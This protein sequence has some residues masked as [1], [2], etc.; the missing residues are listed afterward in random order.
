MENRTATPDEIAAATFAL[1]V[2]LG[3]RLRAMQEQ[4]DESANFHD[5][6]HLA[7]TEWL[8]VCCNGRAAD[9]PRWDNMAGAVATGGFFN[10]LIRNADIVPVSDMTGI[11]EFA[12]IWKKRG[13]VFGTPAYYTFQM[14]SSA[15]P[16]VA[17]EVENNSGHYDVHQG[18]TRLPEIRDVPYLDTVAVMNKVKGRLTLFCV[19][20]HLTQDLAATISI[21]GFAARGTAQGSSTS[22]SKHL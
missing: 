12:G 2:E 16:D 21:T 22:R 17:V 4:I 20:R 9:A 13:R 14:Y 7:F 19:N 18:V 15:Q 1:P 8:F 3:R 10:M 6:A 11:I 5:K